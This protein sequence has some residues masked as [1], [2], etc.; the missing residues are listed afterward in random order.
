MAVAERPPEP[1]V[2]RR[3]RRT[4]RRQVAWPNTSELAALT[5]VVRLLSS[6]WTLQKVRKL[7]AAVD[8]G[9]VDLW[10]LMDDEDLDVESQISA[11]EREYRVAGVP[12]GCAFELHVVPL[13][14][15]DPELIPP[16]E[17]FLE[18]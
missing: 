2:R 7:G 9:Q 8:N 6:L 17:T 5:P 4:R 15:V 16:F 3:A 12:A 18:R 1:V 14:L 13:N 11:M 10:V